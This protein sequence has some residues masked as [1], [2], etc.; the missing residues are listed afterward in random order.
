[1][2]RGIVTA[3]AAAAVALVCLA[4]CDRPSAKV[5]SAGWSERWPQLANSGPRW[6]PGAELVVLTRTGQPGG[7]SA[8]RERWVLL[9]RDS[10]GGQFE[11][12]REDGATVIVALPFHP[13]GP[14]L[15]L[16]YG[17]IAQ[18]GR[19]AYATGFE[20]V[21]VPAG[22]FRCGR[23]W[24][25]FEE[26]DGRMMRVDEWWAPGIPVPVQRWT[27]WEGVVDTLYAPPRRAADVRAGTEWAVLE[28]IRQP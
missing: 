21:S 14:H 15:M 4:S 11:V 5:A 13:R 3:A 2:S 19:Y 25:S 26:R 18:R 22:S 24:R 8:V 6:R 1:M 9:Q 27:R 23:T 20:K 28:R 12:R 17:G 16:G 7:A 10:A